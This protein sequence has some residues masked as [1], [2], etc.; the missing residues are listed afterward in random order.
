[1][2]ESSSRISNEIAVGGAQK[3]RARCKATRS[4][5]RAS[6]TFRV[7]RARWSLGVYIAA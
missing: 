2:P 6:V 4:V 7:A 5:S 3:A 1:M